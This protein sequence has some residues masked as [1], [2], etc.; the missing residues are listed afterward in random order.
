MSE[1]LCGSRISS[2]SKNSHCMWWGVGERCGKAGLLWRDLSPK[3]Q[4]VFKTWP[5]M[6]E[7][8]VEKCCGRI[9]KKFFTGLDG[10][11][12][13]SFGKGAASAPSR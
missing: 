13:G 8:E 4:C 10:R 9:R 7:A 5:P 3:S 11:R 2:G 6:E 12:G 1:V